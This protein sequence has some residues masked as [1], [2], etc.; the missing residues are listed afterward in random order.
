MWPFSEKYPT[1]TLEEIAS[2][3]FDYIVVRGGTAG[4]VV[5]SRLSEDPNNRVLLLERGPAITSW[6]SR[7]PLLSQ[8]FRL[9]TAPAYKWT[10]QPLQ[11]ASDLTNK[12]VSGK[13]LGGTSKINASVYHRSTPAD[14]NAWSSFGVNGWSWSEVEPVFNK[15]EKSLSHPNSPHRGHDGL[16]KNR[17]PPI[18]YKHTPQIIEACSNI[19][20]P[21][22]KDANDPNAQSFGCTRLDVTLG[23]DGLRQSSFDAFLS[24]EIAIARKGNLFVCPGVITTSV[25]L[26]Q[27][28]QGPTAVGVQ[29]EYEDADDKD[30]SVSFYARARREIVISSGAIGTPQL[31]MLSGVGPADHLTNLGIH[32]HKDL[33]GVGNGLQDHSGVAVEYKIPKSETLHAAESSMI[34]VIRELIKFLVTGTG[35]FLSPNPQVSIFAMSKTLD[36]TSD[37]LV[38]ADKRDLDAHNPENICDIEIMPIPANARDPLFKDRLKKSEG[39]FSFLCAGLRP[40]STGTVRLNSLD[41]RAR[42]ECDLRTFSDGEDLVVMRKAVRLALMIGRKMREQGYPMSDLHVPK[43]ESDADLN[44]FIEKDAQSTYHYSSTCRMAPEKQGGVVDDQLRVYGIHGLRIADSSIF[45]TIPAAHLQAPAVMIGER[46]A[47]FMMGS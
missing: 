19:G 8:D 41:P 12:M 3:E 30:A 5:A 46:C 7:V 24:H 16:W 47:A 37:L 32:V 25:H 26:Q 34:L 31:L 11:A 29:M 1:R 9:P 18:Y 38:R 27:T 23:E 33:P 35:L 17:V 39:G 42:P 14:Y 13:A 40:R 21:Y 36:F 28:V 2:R 44:D 43:S 45:P 20:I 4:C 22:L 6:L 15:S 10:S